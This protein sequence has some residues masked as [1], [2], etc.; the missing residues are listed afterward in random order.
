MRRSLLT[1]TW[2]VGLMAAMCL[3]PGCPGPAPIPREAVGQETIPLKAPTN[4]SLVLPKEVTGVAGT[5]ITIRGESS[6]EIGYIAKTSGISVFPADLLTDK[7]AT[8]VV[9]NVPGTYHIIAASCI[10]NKVVFA[11]T[12][13]LVTDGK[14]PAPPGPV[15]PPGPIT[16][17]VTPPTPATSLYFVVI[18]PDGP[19]AP[20]FTAYMANPGWK[21]LM[22]KGHL[23]K[24]KTV[25][26]ARAL[27]IQLPDGTELPCIVTLAVSADG[28][29]STIVRGATRLPAPADIVKLP[30]GVK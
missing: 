2:L 1:T 21:E 10:N 27:G 22:S 7:K 30:E 25:T 29:S 16:P 11:E 23:A 3:Y 14:N 28:K 20:D 26:E 12:T 8:V 15:T 9:A 24:D 18:R 17:P 6:G 13:I 19:A 5:F 4:G